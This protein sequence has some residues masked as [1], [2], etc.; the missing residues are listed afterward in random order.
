MVVVVVIRVNHGPL[1][2][3]SPRRESSSTERALAIVVVVV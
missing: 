3:K 1:T 2:F